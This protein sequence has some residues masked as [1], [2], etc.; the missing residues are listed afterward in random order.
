MTN[1]P[2]PNRTIA[3]ARRAR[4]PHGAPGRSTAKAV[5]ATLALALSLPATAA[6][7]EQATAEVRYRVAYGA[8]P[9]G[10]MDTRFTLDGDDYA[11]DA[12]FGTGGLVQLIRSTKGEASASGN[13][14]EGP[15]AFS[16]S[17]TYGDRSRSRAIA[18]EEGRVGEVEIVP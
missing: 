14:T 5:L 7:A 12:D 3:P 6:R 9:I 8:I 17:Y 1:R 15:D 11:I 18:F 2:T 4:D 16:L 13:L 10:T